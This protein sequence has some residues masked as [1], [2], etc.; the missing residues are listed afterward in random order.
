MNAPTLTEEQ[1]KQY[2]TYRA[3]GMPPE[4][5]LAI[6]TK[7]A[8]NTY[9]PAIEEGIDNILFGEKSL[10]SAVVDG[11]KS[12]VGGGFKRVYDD[13]KKYGAGFALLKSPLSMVAGAGEGVGKI[14]GGVLETADDL[15]GEIVSRTAAPAIDAAVNSEF[16]QNAIALGKDIDTLGRGI[17]GDILDSLNL[18]G[19]SA[20][21]K[22]G[23][24]KAFKDAIVNKT[25]STL[26]VVDDAVD[27]SKKNLKDF[28]TKK[29]DAPVQPNPE[30]AAKIDLSLKSIEDILTE[31]LDD[32]EI[33]TS[34][35]GIT[36]AIA[37]N[38]P[39]E[40]KNEVITRLDEMLKQKGSSFEKL[41]PEEK[42][43][44]ESS[45]KQIEDLLGK[46]DST[47]IV[48]SYLS[49]IGA[50]IDKTVDGSVSIIDNLSDEFVDKALKTVEGIKRVPAAIATRV[51]ASKDRRVVRIAT[52]DPAKAKET[53]L[54]L[55]KTGIVPGVK[56][57]NKTITNIENID[58]AIQRS[59]PKLAKKYEVENIEDFAIAIGLEKKEIFAKI[60]AG[61]EAAGKDGKI[62]DTTPIIA[63]LDLLLKSERA[64]LSSELRR[65]IEKA[66]NELVDEVDGEKIP[67]KITPRGAQDVIADMNAQLQS[68]FRGSTSG[69]NADVIVETLVLNN[70]KKQVDDVVED[71][72]DGSFKELKSEYADLKKMED[73]VVH[74]AVFEAQKGKGLSNLTDIMSAGDVIAG[75]ID[76]AFLARGI[77]QYL[78]KEVLQSLTDK[79]ELI[80]TMFLYGKNMPE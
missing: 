18:V 73:D 56:K 1:K 72:G 53:I 33:L 42:T 4:R 6:A 57:K 68:Y 2:N 77:G 17:P 43:A 16:G 61:L 37:K 29:P 64:N 7:D 22:G 55:Y 80:R 51:K 21:L 35:K 41:A 23:T 58:E 5:A 40:F 10:G 44:V 76:P 28:F 67:K 47:S 20:I 60:E 38:N 74:R 46:D 59:I 8:D 39:A 24:A 13:T 69:T 31:K 12:A 27:N 75:S 3:A 9:N 25:K 52:T 26:G 14:V 63:E 71:L 15:T 49:S 65:A 50:R 34:L 54:D 48:E 45:I 11:V 66:K 78:T 36:E 62:I 79:D 30:A 32:T 70:I 19:V